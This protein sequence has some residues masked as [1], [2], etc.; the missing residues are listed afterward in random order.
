MSKAWQFWS[1]GKE[2]QSRWLVRW[3]RLKKKRLP[4]PPLQWLLLVI[5][6]VMII[7]CW[8]TICQIILHVSSHLSPPTTLEARLTVSKMSFREKL[9]AHFLCLWL[10]VPRVV[11]GEG[12]RH[13]SDCTCQKLYIYYNSFSADGS[14]ES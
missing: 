10:C 6:I 3:A 7:Y 4:V 5:T 8:H 9:F 13:P 2:S 12:G 11:C 1:C 14:K